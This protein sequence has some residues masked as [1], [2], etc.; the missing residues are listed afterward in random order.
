MNM[1]LLGRSSMQMES[2]SGMSQTS[3]S[4]GLSEMTSANMGEMSDSK[5]GA[6]M[7][8]A[9]M[10]MEQA[11]GASNMPSMETSSA[12]DMS[13]DMEMSGEMSKGMDMQNGMDM[14]MPMMRFAPWRKPANA[15]ARF[16]F[17][18]APAWIMLDGVLSGLSSSALR[19]HEG[20][21]EY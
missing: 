15:A 6:S 9:S 2:M 3:S 14:D 13:E 1:D 18:Q 5:M 4:S 10:S 17:A 16:R 20:K 7:S 11:D 8:G 19:H 12:N 21:R